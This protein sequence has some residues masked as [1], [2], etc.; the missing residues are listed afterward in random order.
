MAYDPS[1]YRG[2][3]AH[4]RIGRPPYAPQ[5]D[6]ALREAAALD[7]AGRLL[8]VGCG[9]GT[10]ILRLARY[11]HEAVGV[12]PDGDMLLEA[13]AA[14]DAADPANVRWVQA[15]AEDLP[16]AAPGPYRLVTFGQSF[17]WTDES[18]VAEA[19]YDMLEPGGMMALV[20]HAAAGRPV[21]R[22]PGAPPI[23]HAELEALVTRF[24]GST[25]RAGLGTAALR[26]RTA[27][28][29]LSD[30]RF[31]Q[32]EVVVVPGIPD[33]IRDSDSIVAG[34]L[35]MSW[36]APHLYGSRLHQFTDQAHQILDSADPDGMFWDWA[37]DTEI[38]V[39]RRRNGVAAEG[40]K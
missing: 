20:G 23:P 9:P 7:G 37:G 30:T 33:L 11:F 4:Y 25:R 28:D 32:A 5:L 36:S 2:S 6:D 27:Q 29:L 1:I 8:D 40:P 17:H 10:L 18:R 14:A 24:L 39:A 13:R 34:Y 38:V 35:S 3:A 21:P 22:N 31:G 16:L 12:D 15:V 19:V 26:T